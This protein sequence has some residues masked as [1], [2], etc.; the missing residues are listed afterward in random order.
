M[1]DTI[2][3]VRQICTCKNCGNEAEMIVT[4][5]LEESVER[6]KAS[7]AVLFNELAEQYY[8]ELDSVGPDPREDRANIWKVREGADPRMD[9]I[10]PIEVPRDIFCMV[11]CMH[12][13]EDSL[14]S[15]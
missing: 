9:P 6:M 8:D 14:N 7:P 3:T 12:C 11:K 2:K 15:S 10:E 1:S 4:C 13:C 5:R